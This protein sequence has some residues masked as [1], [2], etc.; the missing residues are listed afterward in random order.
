MSLDQITPR[1]ADLTIGADDWDRLDLGEQRDLIRA[2]IKS[3]SI[4]PGRGD[5]ITIEFL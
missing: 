4:A 5:R 3:V 1:K 2:L